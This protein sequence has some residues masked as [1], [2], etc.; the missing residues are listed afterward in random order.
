MALFACS[1]AQTHEDICCPEEVLDSVATDDT[2][3]ETMPFSPV[4]EG[5]NCV[6]SN[7][8]LTLTY[9]L[10][11]SR[12]SVQE[13]DGQSILFG[14][15]SEASWLLQDTEYTITSANLS[16]LDYE[17]RWESNGFGSGLRITF[18]TAY[19]NATLKTS[20]FVPQD[21][22]S[23]LVQ[24]ELTLPKGA[25]VLKI[26]P[27][28]ARGSDGGGL[29]LGNGTSSAV[30]LDNGSDLYFDFVADVS[31]VGEKKSLFCP[32]G[33]ASNWNSAICTK[34]HNCLVAGFITCDRA[35]PLVATDFVEEEAVDMNGE[36]ALSLFDMRCIYKPWR[37]VGGDGTFSSEVGLLAFTDDP[38]QALVA[39]GQA[40]STAYKKKLW[41]GVPASWN[42]W[43]GGSGHN[44]Y[45]QDIDETLILMNL[46]YAAN[47]YLPWG[48]DY[49]LVD[50]GWQD[51]SGYWFP[52]KERFPDHDGQN[53]MKWLAERIEDAGFIPG[54]WMAL[55]RV[56]VSCE[57]YKE[58]PDWVLQTDPIGTGM[59]GKNE[60]VLDLSHPQVQE[61]L[62]SV[63]HRVFHDWGYKWLKLDFGYYGLF[64]AKYVQE[65]MSAMEAYRLGMKTVR[66]AIGEDV[67]FLGIGAMGSS[68]GIV[69]GQ[70]LTLDNMPL[71]GEA[72][73]VSDQGIKATVLSASHR[74]YLGNTTWINHPDLI[75]FRD[76]F[77]LTMDEAQSFA[78]FVAI[79]SGIFKLGE[80]F[81]FLHEHPEALALTRRL[82][83]IY[84][85][86]PEPLDLF[87]HRFP[88]VFRLRIG[89]AGTQYEVFGLFNW[90]KNY[91]LFQGKDMPE[92]EREQVIPL[93]EGQGA[94]FVALDWL[95]GQLLT[96]SSGSSL[97][98]K[99]VAIQLKPRTSKIVIVKP[100]QDLF[101]GTSRHYAGGAVETKSIETD[102]DAS[103]TKVLFQR[104]VP[105]DITHLYFACPEDLTCNVKELQDA[106]LE[107]IEV[108]TFPSGPSLYDISILPQ[109]SAP[110]LVFEVQ[111]NL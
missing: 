103:T 7:G 72:T 10:A 48:M 40:I 80:S 27:I 65:Q 95:L 21:S 63:L 56:D 71:W 89:E 76:D 49:F 54:L 12:F 38:H 46:E 11:T 98:S 41:G 32:P 66:D 59:L 70:R 87:E 43:G 28:V 109:T 39:Y 52:N 61:Y 67:F 77:G 108:T 104:L 111:K 110:F 107:N 57:L 79:F 23:L 14:A 25:R 3:Q 96:S 1:K 45:G 106:S 51:E 93:P 8:L 36:K 53:G 47:D 102:A 68:F 83:P 55:F 88:E 42:S 74:Y 2:P 75:F 15:Y 73:G 97:H 20:F 24:S 85:G 5:N 30:V 86:I 37:E 84:Q 105:Q 81:V 34:S 33:Y 13:A 29:F 19:S 100:E 18:S 99:S 26:N 101:L 82:I 44:G 9:D 94:G 31:R 50:D 4:V 69:D 58:H 91:D 64:G 22:K 78:L 62:R 60:R 16:S 35:F 92:E 90:G 17:S 6:V